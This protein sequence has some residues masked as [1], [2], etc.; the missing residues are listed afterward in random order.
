M[1]NEFIRQKMISKKG[2]IALFALILLGPVGGY[3][4]SVKSGSGL[5]EKTIYPQ[6]KMDHDFLMTY[7]PALGDIPVER[8]F[9][10]LDQVKRDFALQQNDIT[11]K[12]I[13]GVEW[14]ERGPTG[15]GGRV[16]AIMF[17][18][19]D[20]NAKK[21]WAGSVSGGLWFNNDITDS[22][23]PW[24]QVDERMGN[25][26]IGSITYDP[27]NTRVFY[28][29]T[30]E[31][32]TAIRGRGIY[33]SVDGGL[34]WDL[35]SSTDID[36]G[37]GTGFDFVPKIAVHSN[38]HVFAAV[39]KW[40]RDVKA[41]EQA[42]GSYGGL[43]RSIDGGNSWA[44]MKYTDGTGT[45]KDIP[46]IGDI[47]IA[48]N[49]N[50]YAGTVTFN[51]PGIYRSTDGGASWEDLHY[52]PAGSGAYSR[53]ELAV[54]AQ[55][56]EAIYAVE[57]DGNLITSYR[58]SSDEG[59]SWTDLNFPTE[60]E[61][62]CGFSCVGYAA[63][64]NLLVAVSPDDSL[65]HFI[66]AQRLA[67]SA[68]GGSTSNWNSLGYWRIHPDHHAVAFRPGHPFEAIFATDGGIY[69]S[70]DVKDLNASLQDRNTGFN[71]LQFYA[72]AIEN[73]PGSN[74]MLGGAQDN[75][76]H[77]LS[78][79]GVSVDGVNSRVVLGGDGYL[80]FIDQDQP[81][82]QITS[83]FSG[84]YNLSTNGGTSF[85]SMI[86]LNNPR[87][88]FVPADYD[89]RAN[90]LYSVGD[91]VIPDPCNTGLSR[92]VRIS[93]IPNNVT[94][95]TLPHLWP[96]QQQ[97]SPCPPFDPQTGRHNPNNAMDKRYE[98]T[99]IKV[100]P[101]GQNTLF[102]S[103][104][105]RYW[106]KD[107]NG[108][109]PSPG[110]IGD[111]HIYKVTDSHSA[112][113]VSTEISLT[114][115][116][117]AYIS[118]I[119]VG[120]DDNHL[121][122]T[123][124]NY[125]VTHVWETFDAGV[126]WFNREGNLPDIPVRWAIYNPNNYEEVML[127][128]EVGVWSTDNVS[129]ASPEW[130]ATNEGLADVRCEMLQYRESDGMVAVAT[131]GRGLYTTDVFLKPEYTELRAAYFNDGVRGVFTSSMVHPVVN[132][133]SPNIDFNW[134]NGSPDPKIGSRKNGEQNNF[135]ARWSGKVR[136]E[137]ATAESEA[138]YKFRLSGDDSLR[139][140]LFDPTGGFDIY[141]QDGEDAQGNTAALETNSLTLKKDHWYP[142]RIEY[143]HRGDVPE[144]GN[145]PFLKLEWEKNGNG[146][147]QVVPE[148]VLAGPDDAL[149]TGL[150]GLYYENPQEVYDDFEYDL[151]RTD[152]QINFN[153]DTYLPDSRLKFEDGDFGIRWRGK[154]KPL[155]DGDYYFYT[156]H[157]TDPADQLLFSIDATFSFES[158]TQT[159]LTKTKYKVEGLN[160]GVLYDLVLIYTNNSQGPSQNVRLEWE[161]LDGRQHLQMV[162]A[163]RL[164]LPDD[165]F[166]QAA[167]VPNQVATGLNAQYV[168]MS[169]EF[170]HES[171][172]VND[173]AY[174]DPKKVFAEGARNLVRRQDENLHFDWGGSS[175]DYRIGADYFAANWTALLTLPPGEASGE[176]EFKFE[177]DDGIIFEIGL[178]GSS[179]LNTLIDTWTQPTSPNTARFEM[180]QGERYF[181]K[182][183]Y[184]ER[185]GSASVGPNSE[186]RT[187]LSWRV[188]EGGQQQD[189]SV[190]P[191]SAFQTP[192]PCPIEAGT[193]LAANNP[194]CFNV[195]EPKMLQAQDNEAPYLA[196][197][198]KRIYLL[199]KGEDLVIQQIAQEPEFM[200]QDS[201]IYTI[202]SFVYDTIG[203]SLASISFG[204]ISAHDLQVE[205]YNRQLCADV[206]V[207]GVSFDISSCTSNPETLDFGFKVYPNPAQ[208]YLKLEFTNLGIGTYQVGL[209]SLDLKMIH[210]QPVH[211]GSG[212]LRIP[213]GHLS[214]GVYL[215]SVR[216][217]KG[218]MLTKKV[219]IKP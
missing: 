103:K 146:N 152:Q 5:I 42:D 45:E 107:N 126:T 37:T 66:G 202:H 181:M 1:K 23:S 153:W 67:S 38:G 36:P 158:S 187:I 174:P 53:M 19:N 56:P 58:K 41:P 77:R 173:E 211:S 170:I 178:E 131:F 15:H 2:I 190:V 18:P 162:P 97:A 172:W 176:R 3:F 52:A 84:D 140:W 11:R 160:A 91:E 197:G 33:K 44:K 123:F 161:S 159:D 47:E 27:N 76:S 189:F 150:E 117:I 213:V 101:H 171:F 69:Y 175:P 60:R 92:I 157:G 180:K 6:S 216:S 85:S 127:A 144:T 201:G 31:V 125:G 75:F 9:R 122:V 59:T 95:T 217:A 17:D 7:D 218:E 129:S 184:Y 111:R 199:S 63:W 206:D 169:S 138:Q 80:C 57:A 102:I 156:Y 40:N 96:S 212:E 70:D 74:V 55:E 210:S 179:T 166:P 139:L 8:R 134:P 109:R 82:I 72:C 132:T 124:S 62:N 115:L 39:K 16:R 119:E 79:P 182:A 87:A 137:L 99:H 35:L 214:P 121:L 34:N 104:I 193:L 86:D 89:D 196:P 78:G 25:L 207:S 215:V 112:N 81:H 98:V 209:L 145:N 50:I 88:E 49:G 186:T 148:M 21:V 130:E 147:W 120:K 205:I 167:N 198:F 128:T 219:V 114:G 46:A 10:A 164:F 90:I 32:N 24:I 185:G 73:T 200:I 188:L 135:S 94:Q 133:T 54:S 165:P 118:C 194:G 143:I 136:A 28:V 100:S 110:Y 168:E 48:P 142:I 13:A 195:Q 64:Y 93:G 154:I 149:G 191:P 68:D 12:A 61:L 105:D 71:T 192:D 155:Y 108:N 204:E 83:R 116:P 203:F 30:G 20:P 22:Q 183:R 208:D 113:P 65:L 26:S 4:F 177:A 43:Y 51:Q 106:H 14:T 29:G 141:L 151:V 163:Y